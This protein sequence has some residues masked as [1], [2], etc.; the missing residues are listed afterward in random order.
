MKPRCDDQ[1]IRVF[2]SLTFRDMQAAEGKVLPICLDEIKRCCPYFIGLFG[3][4]CGWVQQQEEYFLDG[5][6]S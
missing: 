5:G 1:Q 3:E 4:Y 2:T 6:E